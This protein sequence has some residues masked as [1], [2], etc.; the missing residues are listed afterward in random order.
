MILET[1]QLT[2]SY[3][4]SQILF[5]INLQLADAET[6]C[7][8]G[9]NGVGKTTTLKT[10]MGM[11]KPHGGS[12]KFNGAEIGKM[13]PYQIARL[14]IAYIPQG[15]HIFPNLTAKENLLISAR[16]RV[17]ST[18]EWTI[19]RIYELFPVLKARENS[20]GRSLSGGEQQMLCIARG[21]M[22]NPRLLLMDEIFEGLA[23]IIIDGLLEVVQQLKKSGVSILLAEQNV[24]HAV[25]ISTRCYILE[26][27][28]VVYSGN[29]SEI[30]QDTIRKY[31]GT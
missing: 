25:Q 16:R 4:A 19:S 8:L 27:G 30:S 29:T 9:R 6:V 12:I 5:G 15:R 21:L 22:Q 14:G 31:L 13:A 1:A 20:R 24:K 11:V 26:K 18:T 10:V 28:Q 17:N 2:A 7:I 23:P 3:G